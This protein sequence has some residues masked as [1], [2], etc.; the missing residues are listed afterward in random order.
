MNS[1][2]PMKIIK[3][4]PKWVAAVLLGSGAVTAFSQ[5]ESKDLY[6]QSELGVAKAGAPIA[7]TAKPIKAVAMPPGQSV[8]FD[9]TLNSP[10][11]QIA[12]AFR[13]FTQKDPEPLI[14]PRSTT[15]VRV[16]YDSEA[17]WVGVQA[18]DPRPNEIV[19]PQARFDRVFRFM[20]FI[21]LYIDPAGKKNSA[22][23]FRVSAIGAT[24]DGLHTAADDNEDFSP[25]YDFEA[26]GQINAQG[27]SVVYRIPY[28]SLRYDPNSILPWRIMVARRTPRNELFLDVSVPLVR[29]AQN[30]ITNMQVL[31][32]FVPPKSK[33][34]FWL[35][36]TLTSVQTNDI[37]PDKVSSN[38]T[39]LSLDFKW[40]PK[41]E[42]VIDGTLNP[43]FTQLEIDQ[44]ELTRNARFAF[45]KQEK[46]PL[47]LESRDLISSLGDVI[48]TRS[49]TDPQW[50]LRASWR[51]DHLQ[52][53]TIATHDR[54]GGLVILPGAFGSNYAPQPAHTTLIGRAQYNGYGF[55]ALQRQYENDRGSNSV[56]AFDRNWNL[57]REWRGR[58]QTAVSSTSALPNSDGELSKQVGQQG[59]SL[60]ARF[61]RN[62][63]Q[64]DQFFGFNWIDSKFRND[65]GFVNQSGIQNISFENTFKRQKIEVPLLGLANE[66]NTS[67]NGNASRSAET[68]KLINASMNVNVYAQWPGK[69][70]SS[71]RVV[72]LSLVRRDENSR[73]MREH[74][75]NFWAN[76]NP[77]GPVEDIWGWIDIGRLA[78]YSA[79]IARPGIAAGL[80]GSFKPSSRIDLNPTFNVR[81]FKGDNGVVQ[82][83][84]SFNLI[85]IFHI[86]PNHFVRLIHQQSGFGRKAEVLYNTENDRYKSL[87]QSLTYVWRASASNAF[88]LGATRSVAGANDPKNKTNEFYVKW[89]QQLF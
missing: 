10:A 71:M 25:D 76:Y 48:Y 38:K 85:G 74:I 46:R 87:S 31:E 43:D 51:S 1:N 70:Q 50:A 35:R 67:V 29:E 86:R 78:D 22:Q 19:A 64:L 4:L 66:L 52:G 26:K 56:I 16:L 83:E 30:F 12:P 8:V 65:T 69:L 33:S 59:F 88:Y 37:S 9:G 28:S 82:R 21:A 23:F 75:V 27:F 32:G 58:V 45:Y 53:T 40:S 41:T 63:A 68:G 39:K 34:F 15:E 6:S 73:L 80:G 7:T 14:A 20:D 47:F 11:W 81:L 62:T 18:N 24:A 36:P 72:P 84:H 77:G 2:F 79:N 49:I 55:I 44:I 89:Q 42:L 54:G 61:I 13:E 57:N 17:L 5:N 3:N 60:D